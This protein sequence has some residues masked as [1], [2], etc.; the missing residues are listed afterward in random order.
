[1]ATLISDQIS[2]W[3]GLPFLSNCSWHAKTLLWILKASCEALETSPFDPGV[4]LHEALQSPVPQE[5]S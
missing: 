5:G 3:V 4:S 1:M 2:A